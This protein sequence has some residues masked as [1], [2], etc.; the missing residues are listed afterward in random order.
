[1][2]SS[3]VAHFLCVALRLQFGI[4]NIAK[5]LL[6]GLVIG[7]MS[8]E[9]QADDQALCLITIEAVYFAAM[10]AARPFCTVTDNLAN[11]MGE[12]AGFLPLA[13]AVFGEVDESTCELNAGSQ[14]SLMVSAFLG[15]I[16]QVIA[17]G[18]EFLPMAY[19]ALVGVLPLIEGLRRAH[20]AIAR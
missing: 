16:A 8:Q 12:A 2:M 6:V 10:I 5:M 4:F 18:Q 20:I 17:L 11:L 3:C 9:H 7:V 1:M 13:I 19:G 14:T 15:I